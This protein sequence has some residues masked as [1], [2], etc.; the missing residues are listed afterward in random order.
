[1]QDFRSISEHFY[2]AVMQEQVSL[3]LLCFILNIYSWIFIGI[4]QVTRQVGNTSSH[5]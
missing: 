4:L 3:R 1:M 2:S 5:Y